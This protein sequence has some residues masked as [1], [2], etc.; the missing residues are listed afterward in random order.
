[1][2]RSGPMFYASERFQPERMPSQFYENSHKSIMTHGI[3][4]QQNT[5]NINVRV[6]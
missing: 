3:N 2:I 5:Q 4:D 6:E 1:M